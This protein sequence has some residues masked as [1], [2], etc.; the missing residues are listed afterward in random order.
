MIGRFISLAAALPLSPP[1]FLGGRP[2]FFAGFW[3]SSSSSTSL[4]PP[5]YVLGSRFRSS[6]LRPS[7]AALAALAS[8]LL[9]DGA[10]DGVAGGAD[11][12]ASGG[13]VAESMPRVPS[14]LRGG[15]EGT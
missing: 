2:R 3:S 4:S 6:R 11:A 13:L 10:D 8:F 1:S 9:L 15:R 14:P 7:S 12:A 5:L